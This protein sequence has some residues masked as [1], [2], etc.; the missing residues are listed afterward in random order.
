L[1]PSSGFK[2]EATH[3]PNVVVEW[4]TLLLRI[5]KV[6]SS[7]LGTETGYLDYSFRRFPQSI[8]GNDGIVP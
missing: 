1:S 6:P 7:N 8:Q 4:L 3:S 2:T 5:R